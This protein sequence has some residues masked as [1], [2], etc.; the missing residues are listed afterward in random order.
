MRMASNNGGYC[1]R[2]TQFKGKSVMPHGF[3]GVHISRNAVIGS[4]YIIFQNVTITNVEIK[5]N[6]YIDSGS[7]LMGPITIGSDVKIEPGTV[8]VENILDNVTVVGMKA[9]IISRNE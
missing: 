9:R 1:G 3:H 6:C 2:T 5:E 4:N 8:V 7:V